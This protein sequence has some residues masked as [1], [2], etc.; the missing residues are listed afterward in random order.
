M[1]RGATQLQVP[2][3]EEAELAVMIADRALKD[4]VMTQ[5]ND[6]VAIARMTFYGHDSGSEAEV[7]VRTSLMVNFTWAITDR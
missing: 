5:G 6:F 3:F 4:A 2:L 7:A 1:I